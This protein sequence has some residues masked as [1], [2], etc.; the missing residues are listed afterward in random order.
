[1]LL[2]MQSQYA[3]LHSL[4]HLLHSTTA[5]LV[6]IAIGYAAAIVARAMFL[7]NIRTVKSVARITIGNVNAAHVNLYPAISTGIAT[8][9]L[10]TVITTTCNS[11]SFSI[12]FLS[13][14]LNILFLLS[15]CCAACSTNNVVMIKFSPV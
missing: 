15:C 5:I 7:P 12:N 11:A 10:L 1:M 14:F 8:S 6:I 4:V 3:L 13:M 2:L 9:A